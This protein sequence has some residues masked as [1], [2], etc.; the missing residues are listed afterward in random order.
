ML[1]S[2]NFTGIQVRSLPFP[3]VPP[4]PPSFPPASLYVCACACVHVCA[5]ACVHVCEC[6]CM[7]VTRTRVCCAPRQCGPQARLFGKRYPPVAFNVRAAARRGRTTSTSCT[8]RRGT[9]RSPA[10]ARRSSASHARRACPPECRPA[11]DDALTARAETA[12]DAVRHGTAARP[13]LAPHARHAFAA[14]AAA[15]AASSMH[16]SPQRRGRAG[17]VHAMGY[18]LACAEHASPQREPRALPEPVGSA[19]QGGTRAHANPPRL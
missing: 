3:S 16:S 15:A 9:R 6:A 1:I 12:S 17:V 18:R 19:L 11:G 4:V 10:S 14:A 8:T 13:S 7:H 2:Q 5:C